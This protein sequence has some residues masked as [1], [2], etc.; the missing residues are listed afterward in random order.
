MFVVRSYAGAPQ[1]TRML[2]SFKETTGVQAEA[3]WSSKLAVALSQIQKLL[4]EYQSQQHGAT[5]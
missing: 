1:V 3:Q 2:K 5:I 4:Q